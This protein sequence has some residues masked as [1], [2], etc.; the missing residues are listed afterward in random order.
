MAAFPSADELPAPSAAG[1]DYPEVAAAATRVC[2]SLVG[3][4]TSPA[5]RDVVRQRPVLAGLPA[6]QRQAAGARGQGTSRPTWALA[7]GAEKAGRGL[8]G[9][10]GNHG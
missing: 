3:R 1:A 10:E 8:P 6:E 5:G 7:A 9:M 2:S 4:L